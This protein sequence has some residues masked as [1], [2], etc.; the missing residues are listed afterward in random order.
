MLYLNA[1]K[2]LTID[3]SVGGIILYSLANN[4]FEVVSTLTASSTSGTAKTFANL[5]AGYYFIDTTGFS[6]SSPIGT[7][8][9]QSDPFPCFHD[10]AY[11]DYQLLFAPCTQSASNS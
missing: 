6:G 5:P 7:L 9:Y 2:D 4:T 8:T 11:S 3:L 10:P 1:T